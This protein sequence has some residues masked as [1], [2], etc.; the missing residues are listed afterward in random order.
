MRRFIE[1][2]PILSSVIITV[3]F[4]IISNL[5]GDVWIFG[6]SAASLFGYEFAQMVIPFLFVV[7]FSDIRVYKRKGIGKTLLA[8]GY[9]AVSQSLLLIMV[10]AIT[11]LTPETEW[12]SPWGVAYGIVVLFGIGFREE[13]IFRGVIVENIAK[14]YIKD[15]PGV[16]ITAVASGVVFGV[17]HMANMFAG[18][19]LMSAT[20]Q[21][22]VAMG[23]GFYF[24]AIYLR[25]GSI[26]ALI[27]I[28]SL[29][30]A[31]SMFAPTFT[32]NNGDP[33]EAINSLSI[34]NLA[35][36]F[37]LTWLGLFLLRESKCDEIVEKFKTSG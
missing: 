16:Y 18:V 12:C 25:G 26:W 21:S 32:V 22:V 1:G 9:M 31:A 28:H 15:R 10:I 2:Y 24:A 17:M 27:L 4:L 14:K 20:I 36:F 5:A 37:I 35:P 23:A 34:L 33:I 3:L 7:F 6:D 29:A 11:A 30:D 19:D 13:S 8:G